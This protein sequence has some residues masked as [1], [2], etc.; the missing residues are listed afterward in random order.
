[1]TSAQT[2][3]AEVSRLWAPPEYSTLTEW[4]EKNF[5]LSSEAS[6]ET[7]L[8]EAKSFQREPLNAFTDPRV[9]TVV[10]QSATQMLKTTTVLVALAYIIDRDPG[11]CMVIQPRDSDVEKFSKIRL[12]PMLRDMPCLRRKLITKSRSTESTLDYKKFNGGHIALTAAGSPGNLAALPIRYLLCDEIDKYPR[13]AGP[14]GDPISLAKKRTITYR[15]RRKIILTCSPTSANTS[16]IAKAYA[17]SDKREYYVPCPHAQC[18]EFQTLKWAQVKWDN[19]LPLV[20]RPASAY[21]QCEHCL[22]AWDEQ[23]RLRAVEDGQWRAGAAFVGAAG[24]KIS[25]LYS[26]WRTLGEIVADFLDKKDDREQLRTF[27]NTTLAELWEEEGETPDWEVLYARREAYPYGAEPGRPNVEAVVPVG[28]LFLTAGVDVQDDRLEYEVLAHGRGKETWSVAYGIIKILDNNVPAK[29]SDPRLW[30]ELSK[31]LQADWKHEGGDTMP[32]M[33]M[34]IDTGNRPKPVYDFALKHAQPAYS[35]AGLSVYV[36]RTV[37]PIKGSSTE[38]LRLIAA[39]SGEDAARKR[40]GVKIVSIG[41]AVA[42]Q[43]IYDALRL[44]RPQNGQAMPGYHHHPDYE[45]QYFIGLCN[46]KRVVHGNGSVTWEKVGRNEPL[47]CKVYAVAAAVVFGI[48]RFTEVHWRKLERALGILPDQDPPPQSV[49][50]QFDRQPPPA[51]A[52]VVTKARG[53]QI[54]SPTHQFGRQGW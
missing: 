42:K 23:M 8:F 36:P 15:R 16:R 40:R 31:V 28:G 35:Q 24:F 2:L 26:P 53:R 21:Y 14:E 6:A 49:E 39:V 37:I 34:A 33:A 41:T 29:S 3:L 52:A 30:Q 43:Q 38:T 17:A 11:P 32:I 54:A 13:S 9:E 20:E 47:D 51:P 1:M 5:V 19:S 7:G 45:D 50:H 27:I 12:A 46:E 44:P 4:A 18:G 25:E 48:E 22:G 10:I